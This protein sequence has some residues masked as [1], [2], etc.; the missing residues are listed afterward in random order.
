MNKIYNLFIRYFI[1]ILIALPNLE[2]F[3]FIFTPLTI[4]STYLILALFYPILLSG[5]SL[6]LDSSVIEIVRGCV[7][8][9]AYYLLL[10]LNLTTPNIHIKKRLLLVLVS[11]IL[12]FIANILRIVILSVLFF[13]NFIYFDIIHTIFWYFLSILFVIIIWFFLVYIFKIKS[14]PFYTDIKSLY[15]HIKK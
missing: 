14:I 6:I 9:S 5:S 10:M 13:D 1:L 12:F 2:V 8:P 3:I 7:A 15:K 4:Y 11:F